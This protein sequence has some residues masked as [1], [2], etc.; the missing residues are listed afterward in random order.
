MKKTVVT[1]GLLLLTATI[2]FSQSLSPTLLASQGGFD[3]SETMV[4]E[5]TLGESAIETVAEKNVIYS[6]GF[7]QPT[8]KRS[9]AL[10][11]IKDEMLLFPNPV[12]TFLNVKLI[13]EKDAKVSTDIYNV[14]GSLLKHFENE[15]SIS[16]IVKLDVADLP[17]GIYFVKITTANGPSDSHK[18][19]K[20]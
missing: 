3:K 8:L 16:K 6:Q 13:S 4:L 7:I 5:W 2:S 18:I 10:I 12:T 17:S 11:Q 19:I 15:F 14:N 1:V 9:L 20:Y